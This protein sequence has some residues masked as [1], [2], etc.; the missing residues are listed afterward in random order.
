[1]CYFHLSSV[2]ENDFVIINNRVKN[3]ILIVRKKN[4]YVKH[5]FYIYYIKKNVKRKFEK[6]CAKLF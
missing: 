5:A 2:N 1:M 6:K 3:L 4:L